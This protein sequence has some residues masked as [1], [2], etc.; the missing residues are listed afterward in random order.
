MA[1]P[2]FG[3]IANPINMMEAE[4]TSAGSSMEAIETL[5][6]RFT[7]PADACMSYRVLF[8]KLKEFQQDLHQHIHLENNILF[9]KALELEAELYGSKN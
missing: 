7:V 1:R 4:H 8:S 2:P 5:S 6:S 3:T 9:P